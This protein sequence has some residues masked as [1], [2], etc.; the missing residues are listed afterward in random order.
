MLKATFLLAAF[1]F[2][3]APAVFAQEGTQPRKPGIGVVHLSAEPYTFDTAEQHRL[4]VT[5]VAKGLAHPFSLAFLPNGDALVVERGVGLRIIHD[6]AGP[7]PRVDPEMIGGLPTFPRSGTSGIQDVLLHPKF[8]SNGLVYFSYNKTRA[9]EH[10]QHPELAGA[11]ARGKIIGSSLTDIHEIFAGEWRDQ[12]SSLRMVFAP[13]DTLY[14][15]TGAP[16]SQAAADLSSVYGK[17]LRIRDDG[18]IPPENPFVG[19][20]GMRPEIFAYGMRDQLGIV[21]HAA[22]GN[23]LATDHGPQGG[24]EIN[25]IRP[26][27]D[28]G[29]P[30][31]SFGRQYDGSRVSELPAIPGIEQPI[32]LWIPSIAPSGLE[33]YTGNRFPDW[34]GNLFVGSAQRG[35]IPRTGGLERVVLNQKLQELRRESLLTDLHLRIR[36]VRQG[37]DGLLYVLTEQNGG[38]PDEDG[39]V[40]RL[41]PAP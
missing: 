6:A 10:Q 33:V 28:Y 15:T 1:P 35:E 40:L 34:Q 2:M 39:A 19:K 37:P 31:Y 24:D 23:I 17:V 36:F 7:H 3:F 4:R 8:A 18:S 21:Y 25:L 29:W 38:G 30:K 16:F 26:G 32:I 9:A 5:I 22:S 41:E 12:S 11:V 27:L 14:I 13:D 20:S